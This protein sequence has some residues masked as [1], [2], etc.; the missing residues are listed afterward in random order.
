MGVPC[1][2]QASSQ[3]ET[4]QYE[5]EGGL[6]KGISG[7]KGGEEDCEH[8]NT[9]KHHTPKKKGCI[10]PR[11]PRSRQA[12]LLRPKSTTRTSKQINFEKRNYGIYSSSSSSM[13]AVATK[14]LSFA[15]RSP[16][17]ARTW[18]RLGRRSPPAPRRREC[19]KTHAEREPRTHAGATSK[20]GDARMCVCSNAQ[21]TGTGGEKVRE[22]VDLLR[23]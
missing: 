22:R 16:L 19:D 1:G 12:L 21:D 5:T 10:P 15:S 17:G 14:T 13:T 23:G 2:L 4:L 20:Q 9:P 18:P 8:P 6:D 3:Q 11:T 7:Q